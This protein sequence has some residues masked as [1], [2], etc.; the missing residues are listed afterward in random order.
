MYIFLFGLVYNAKMVGEERPLKSCL[1]LIDPKWKGKIIMRSP[2]V[3]G[4][5][6]YGLISAWKYVFKEDLSAWEDYCKKLATQVARY[7]TEPAMFMQSIGLGEFPIGFIDSDLTTA[8]Y[9]EK[10]PDL[11]WAPFDDLVWG[12]PVN[13]HINKFAEHPNAAR[14]FYEFV[15]S[16]EGQKIGTQQGGLPNMVNVEL[17]PQQEKLVDLLTKCRFP[18][19]F[20]WFVKEDAERGALWD[21]RIRAIFG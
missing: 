18:E 8:Q 4:A 5:A 9:R 20:D 21:D 7:E 10:F 1:D 2:L 11:R 16:P 19:S 12:V 6:R 15:L 13:I 14:L 3:K 17:T